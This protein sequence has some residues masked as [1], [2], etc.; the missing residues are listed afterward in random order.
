MIIK[1]G[2]KVFFKPYTLYDGAEGLVLSVNN[3]MA[4]VKLVDTNEVVCTPI[5][6]LFVEA[7]AENENEEEITAL[8]EMMKD[9]ARKYEL[10]AKETPGYFFVENR[11]PRLIISIYAN[12][13]DLMLNNSPELMRLFKKIYITNED[14]VEGHSPEEKL[15]MSEMYDYMTNFD[16][17]TLSLYTLSDLHEKLYSKCPYP[18][19]GGKYRTENVYLP[20]AGVETSNYDM[21]VPSISALRIQF[22]ELMSMPD[23]GSD[24]F[25]YVDKA[26]AIYCRLVQIHPFRDGNGRAMRAFL[27]LMLRKVNLPPVYVDFDEKNEYHFAL[28]QANNEGNCGY[29]RSYYYYKI[30][31]S[32]MEIGLS[33]RTATLG[34]SFSDNPPVIDEE[35]IKIFPNKY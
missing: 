26:L 3:K 1:F 2:D 5:T 8:I 14:F 19:F 31:A 4:D 18:E 27:N 30:Y 10:L 21:I 12:N 33:S 34:K 16:I 9:H 28:N 7:K 25:D 6:D 29:I 32:I 24:V 35:G 17:E 13:H 11:I 15:G 23:E 22:E 20:G